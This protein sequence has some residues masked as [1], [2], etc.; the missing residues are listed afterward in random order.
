MDNSLD[1]GVKLISAQRELSITERT[2]ALAYTLWIERG[3]PEGTPGV[4]WFEAERRLTDADGPDPSE[5]AN[6]PVQPVIAPSRRLRRAVAL[7]T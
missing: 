1:D 6:H 4:D 2:E 7:E 5:G 3:C